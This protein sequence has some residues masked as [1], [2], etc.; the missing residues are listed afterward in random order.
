MAR[1][2]TVDPKAQHPIYG[3]NME[4]IKKKMKNKML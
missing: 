3:V 1:K 2:K 4:E